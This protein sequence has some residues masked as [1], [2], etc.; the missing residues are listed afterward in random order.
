MARRAYPAAAVRRLAAA[1]LGRLRRRRRPSPG[2]PRRAALRPGRPGPRTNR[3]RSAASTTARCCSAT[4]RCRSTTLIAAVLRRVATETRSRHRRPAVGVDRWRFPPLGRAPAADAARRG[5]GRRPARART[6]CPSRSPRAVLLRRRGARPGPVGRQPRRLRPRRRHVRRQSWCAAPRGGFDVLASEGLGD[7][8]RPGHR[9][10]DR[11][12]PRRSRRRRGS[13]RSGAGST[14]PT[15][16]ADRRARRQLWD[17]VRTAKEMLSR[18]ATTTIH[19]PLLDAR[20]AARPRA[21]R[22]A[23]RSRCWPARS[24]P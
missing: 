20:R 1:A 22:A 8:R 11:R 24:R 14:G 4:A 3:T 12:H 7:M 10:G 19:V 13:R 23:G 6:W 9:R 17:D 5:R 18:S 16:T 2:R 21:V 15:T